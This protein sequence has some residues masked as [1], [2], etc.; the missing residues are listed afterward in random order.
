[1]IQA[2]PVGFGRGC[3]VSSW[4]SAARPKVAVGRLKAAPVLGIHERGAGPG[5]TASLPYFTV[6]DM[7]AALK[8]V[9]AL[10]E[11]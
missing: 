5:D 1:M 3:S 4:L 6:A 9:S 10:G 7:D 11:A 2:A 8:Q